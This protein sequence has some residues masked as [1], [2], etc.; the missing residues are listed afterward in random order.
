MGRYSRKDMIEFANFAKSYQSSRNVKEAY[1]AYLK[2]ARL[3]PSK[4]RDLAEE[5]GKFLMRLM[6]NA[7]V[8][9]IDGMLVKS[10]YAPKEEINDFDF[11]GRNFKTEFWNGKTKILKLKTI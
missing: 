11:R 5:G 4:K 8:V 2:G 6:L 7:A 3:V 9:Y 10:R 1:A